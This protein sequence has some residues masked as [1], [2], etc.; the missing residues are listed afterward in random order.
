M[1]TMY[2]HTKFGYRKFSIS[3]DVS[4][5]ILIAC[6]D[7]DHQYFHQT[8]WLI[9]YICEPVWRNGKASKQKG[10]SLIL[11][12]PLSSKVVVCGHFVPHNQQNIKMAL[13]TAHLNEGVILLVTVSCQVQSPSSHTSWDLGAHQYLFRENLALNKFNQTSQ[14][15][16]SFNQVQPN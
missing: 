16:M 7:L 9:I 11:C 2:H 8:L 13:I 3:D 1:I 4:K 10:F 15:F 6:Y 5:Q 14:L 12:S